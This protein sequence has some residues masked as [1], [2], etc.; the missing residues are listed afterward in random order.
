M[1][2]DADVLRMEWALV[3]ETQYCTDTILR[4]D[5]SV[6]TQKNLKG[7]LMEQ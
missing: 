6:M 7:A 5:L 3:A 4:N 1:K 2:G